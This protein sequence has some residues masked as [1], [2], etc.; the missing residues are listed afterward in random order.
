LFSTTSERPAPISEL[1]VALAPFSKTGCTQT[2]RE[3]SVL[4]ARR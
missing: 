4:G 3:E 2:V 1:S